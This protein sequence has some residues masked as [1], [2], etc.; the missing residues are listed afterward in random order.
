MTRS[1][2]LSDHQGHPRPDRDPL[3]FEANPHSGTCTRPKV[4]TPSSKVADT[5]RWAPL[6]I[7]PGSVEY[8]NRYHDLI[9]A[10][11]GKTARMCLPLDIGGR[12][13]EFPWFG[14][15]AAIRPTP[16]SCSGH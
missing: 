7:F 6:F 8:F 16:N 14:S 15:K 9:G 10:G 5:P 2:A 1:H 12:G 13:T 3:A 4:Q 11:L